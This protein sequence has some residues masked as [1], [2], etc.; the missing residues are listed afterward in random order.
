MS[1]GLHFFGD[2]YF[3]VEIVMCGGGGGGGGGGTDL[4]QANPLMCRFEA[5]VR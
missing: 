5:R 2:G 4:A 1:C 3:S